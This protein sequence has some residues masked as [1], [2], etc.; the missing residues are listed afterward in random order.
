MELAKYILSILKLAPMIVF[1]WGFNTPIAIP[2]GLR[3]KV[4]GFKHQGLVDIIYNDGDDLFKIRL[5][6]HGDIIKE[7]DGVYVD[8]LIDTIDRYVERV[9]N[10]KENVERWLCE[11]F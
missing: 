8:T 3:F 4:Q 5:I 7:V 10:Y 2:N 1:S 6:K 11:A 9:D